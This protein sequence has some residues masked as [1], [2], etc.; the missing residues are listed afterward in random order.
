MTRKVLIVDDVSMFVEL[1]RDY[2]Q[3][4]AVKVLTARNGQEALEISLDERPDLV[5]MDLHMPVMNG[6]DSCRCIKR[7]R[8]LQGTF[9]VLIT[10]VGKDDERRLCL[11]AGCDDF[12][13]KPLDRRLFLESAHRFLPAIDRRDRRINCRLNVTYRLSG[14]TFSGFVANLSRHGLYLVSDL[15]VDEGTMIELLFAL[16]EPDC[17]II[18]TGGRVARPSWGEKQ[19]K[20]SFPPGFA[21]E[22]VSLTAQAAQSLARFIEQQPL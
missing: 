19:L 5:F 2:L 16:P 21:V 8:R 22:F 10:S 14:G 7:E 1:E 6:A 13:T 18:Q 11:K 12:L 15:A 17:S 3:L 9:V 4:S 20:S